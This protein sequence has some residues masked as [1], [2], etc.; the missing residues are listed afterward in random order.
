MIS[1]P[2]KEKVKKEY[3]KISRT[4]YEKAVDLILFY[5]MNDSEYVNLFQNSLGYFKNKIERVLAAE[6]IYY[7]NKHSDINIADFTSYILNNEELKD[8]CL[9]IISEYG[10]KELNKEEFNTC[11]NVILDI[12]H[13]DKI[14]ELKNE[15]KNE[16]D[17]EKKVKLINQ[18]AELKKDV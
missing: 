8:K 2:K 14:K 12:Y 15:I 1:T 9:E 11:I 4:K 7:K 16:T 6:I 13:K 18:L 17:L 5:M 3:N 10:S